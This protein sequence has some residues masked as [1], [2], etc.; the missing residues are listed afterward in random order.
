M[1][2]ILYA[3]PTYITHHPNLPKNLYSPQTSNTMQKREILQIAAA[4]IVFAIII[5]FYPIILGEF[6]AIPQAI[7]FSAIIILVSVFSRKLFANSLDAGVEH[8]IWQWQRFGFKPHYKL[9]KSIPAGILFPLF[10]SVFSIGI[11]KIPTLLSY[12]TRALKTRAAKR[13]GHYSFSEMTDWHNALIGSAGIVSLLLLAVIAYF[14]P[15]PGFEYLSRLATYYAFVNL[16]PIS[17]LD[18]TQI[19][20]G[21]R[22]LWTTLA[23]ISAVFLSYA[24]LII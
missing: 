2:F 20:F 21:S 13:F 8:E 24:L 15:I 5:A 12:E 14:L 1:V 7:L 3:C 22:I 9:N 10:F 19:F 4:I 17:K 6:T 11:L 23:I 16:L 18:G